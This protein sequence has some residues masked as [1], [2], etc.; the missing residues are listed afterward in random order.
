[1]A[2]TIPF[3]PLEI[4]REV[5][6]T[7]GKPIGTLPGEC[8]NQVIVDVGDDSVSAP[9]GED[10]AGLRGVVAEAKDKGINLK[11]VV[12]SASPPI[13]APLRDVARRSAMPIQARPSW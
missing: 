12:L 11:I 13:E 7:V 10:V 2:V 3:I 5:C 1:M 4:P 6:S 8:M 9:V